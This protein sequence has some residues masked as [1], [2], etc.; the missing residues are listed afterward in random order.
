MIF[1]VYYADG[2][3]VE[4]STADHWQAAPNAG[5]Q[6]IARFPRDLSVRWFGVDDRD[7]WTGEDNYD[8]F[9]WGVKTGTLL[10]DAEYFAIWE[11]ACG[12][13]ST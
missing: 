12:D 1:R 7:L 8:P 6:V 13:P 4:G 3:V 11:R 10:S 2:S 5:V 9:G